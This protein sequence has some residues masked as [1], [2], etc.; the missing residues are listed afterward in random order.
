VA[1]STANGSGGNKVIV[2]MTSPTQAV[3]TGANSQANFGGASGYAAPASGYN[4]YNSYGWSV[5]SPSGALLASVHT[6]VPTLAG[7]IL[8]VGVLGANGGTGTQTYT[9]TSEYDFNFT[10][11]NNALTMGFL[12]NAGYSGGFVDLTLTISDGAQS[13]TENFT[14]LASAQSF[15]AQGQ[16]LALFN[17]V[18]A[19]DL[20]VKY[21]LDTN[22]AQGF[23]I[24]Y[25]IGDVAT[26]S[27][28]PLP[29][30]LPLLFGGLLAFLFVR[31][32]MPGVKATGTAEAGA[33]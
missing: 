1:Q 29:P 6:M 33:T 5:A 14:S 25:A 13:I 3:V 20:T 12:G 2:T 24:N 31:R 11:Q 32:G 18:G 26:T 27:A 17:V 15:F 28:V 23:G 10:G 22:G 30:S 19:V 16:T 21:T 8:G 4:G 9:G 7:T